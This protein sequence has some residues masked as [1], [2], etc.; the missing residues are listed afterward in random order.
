MAERNPDDIALAE[1]LGHGAFGDVWLAT[2]R[3]EKVAVK[4]I[5]KEKAH[6]ETIE[7]FKLD[8]SL[9]PTLVFEQPTPRAIAGHLLGHVAGADD[10]YQGD[11]R[12]F[13]GG[14]GHPTS[15]S[16]WIQAPAG[17]PGVTG[18]AMGKGLS[19]TGKAVG[20][21]V[22]AST[23]VSGLTAFTRCTHAA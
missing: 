9:S 10:A 17:E 22:S 1:R 7:R 19:V 16:S 4:M 14:C 15:L 8:G 2:F 12:V 3:A 6:K 21:G 5:T 23:A 18:E 11:E 20:Q 13:K